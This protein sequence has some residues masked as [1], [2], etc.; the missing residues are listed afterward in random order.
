MK[1]ELNVDELKPAESIRIL[2][3]DTSIQDSD[4]AGDISEKGPVS[5]PKKVRK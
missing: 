2:A 5:K 1:I 4:D 3:S